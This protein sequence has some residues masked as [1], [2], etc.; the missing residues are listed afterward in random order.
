MLL[1]D[2]VVG[3]FF[4]KPCVVKTG[5]PEVS[6]E[7]GASFEIKLAFLVFNFEEQVTHEQN[8]HFLDVFHLDC[9]D[10]I[11]LC[12]QTLRVFLQVL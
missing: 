12:D 9:V 5:D 11:D 8:V 3:Y 4:N 1:E 2:K 7:G 6:D 10:T